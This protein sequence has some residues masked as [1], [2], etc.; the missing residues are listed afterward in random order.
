[1]I[2]HKSL[3]HSGHAW[4][5][6]SVEQSGVFGY[7]LLMAWRSYQKWTQIL[8]YVRIVR[9]HWTNTSLNAGANVWFLF[10]YFIFFMIIVIP[11]R[12]GFSFTASKMSRSAVLWICPI[13]NS[14]LG[15]NVRLTFAQSIDMTH[16][17]PVFLDVICPW[18]DY[19]FF[20]FFLWSVFIMN[21]NHSLKLLF[22]RVRVTWWRQR[23]RRQ[24]QRSLHSNGPMGDDCTI[25]SMYNA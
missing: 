6:S 17:K 5:T 1:M 7:C 18:N 15:L 13:V 24:H 4:E 25:N 12:S 10:R 9:A 3:T 11:V 14:I 19:L 21:E 16:D 8:Y 22:W 23:W 20:V 2:L